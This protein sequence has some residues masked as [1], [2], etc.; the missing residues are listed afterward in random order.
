MMIKRESN[1]QQLILMMLFGVAAFVVCLSL[2]SY[3]HTTSHAA[4]SRGL[5]LVS[6]EAVKNTTMSEIT[7]QIKN[8]TD[9]E[10]LYTDVVFNL[11][12]AKGDKIGDVV[13][14]SGDLKPGA[15]WNFD[16][17][18]APAEIKTYKVAQISGT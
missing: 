2:H 7:G 11:Y 6:S 16:A 14:N 17:I 3:I 4:Q 5:E 13:D 12:D 8:N 1:I 18:G 9:K 15:I 10:F